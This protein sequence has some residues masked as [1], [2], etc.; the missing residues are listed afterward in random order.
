[1]N[2][3]RHYK[4]SKNSISS[5]E[6]YDVILNWIP[7]GSKV[8]DLGCGDGSLLKLLEKKGVTGEGIEISKTGVKASKG[9]GLKVKQGNIDT[10]LE[11]KDNHFD[12]AICNVTL[13]MVSY[14]E[15]LIK[16][17]KRISKR[18]IISFPNFAF[19]LNRLDMLINGRMPKVCLFGYNWYSTGHIHQLSLKDFKVFCQSQNTKVINQHHIIPSTPLLPR[20][21]LE[22]FPNLFSM[23]SV[24]LTK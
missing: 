6:E 13:Q 17:M 4:F 3:N 15:V 2:D 18:Q 14:P 21:F 20:K 1:M 19:V 9:K 12:F 8:I 22:K 7:T 24:L 5:R 16:E 23:T 10:H 11:Y